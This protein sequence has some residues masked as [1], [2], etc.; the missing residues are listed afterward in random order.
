MNNIVLINDNDTETPQINL[1]ELYEYKKQCDKNTLKSYNIVLQRIHSRI[2]I[3]SRQKNN[4]QFCWF[5]VPEVMIGVPK[6]DVSSCI[7]YILDQ[8][9]KNGF[10]IKYT[11]PNLIFI[12]WKDWVPDYVRNEIKKK[13][14]TK[15]DGNGNIIT[16][17]N[18]ELNNNKLENNV[19]GILK[20]NNLDDNKKESNKYTSINT[21]TPTGNSIYSNQVLQKIQNKTN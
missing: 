18:I 10:S 21:Y 5:V 2:K 14:G 19:K 9:K 3:T 20:I 12:S 17:K 15:I 13:T 6:Y 7:A 16:E 8:L 1:D 11:H 4:I